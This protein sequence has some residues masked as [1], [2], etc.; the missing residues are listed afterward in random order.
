MLKLDGKRVQKFTE[1]PDQFKRQFNK[2][3]YP[4]KH[5]GVSIVTGPKRKYNNDGS[6]RMREEGSD[7]EDQIAEPAL[8]RGYRHEHGTEYD[9]TQ[10]RL[11]TFDVVEAAK[12]R[13]NFEPVT[14]AKKMLQQLPSENPIDEEELLLGYN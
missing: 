8:M 7:D 12:R 6:K 14:E 3:K 9:L 10:K 5:D 4:K 11:K 13:F 1:H 2:N